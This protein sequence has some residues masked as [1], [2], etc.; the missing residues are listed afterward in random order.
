MCATVWE[1]LPPESARAK[2][3]EDYAPELLALPTSPGHSFS[4]CLASAAYH[5]QG[6]S[7]MV[8]AISLSGVPREICLG[9]RI[10][11]FM[12]FGYAVALIL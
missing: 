6:S 3:E 1:P 11:F 2:E 10:L 9:F 7:V 8:D 5:A 4:L 12:D